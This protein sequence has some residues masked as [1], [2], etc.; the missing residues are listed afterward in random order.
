[1]LGGGVCVTHSLRFTSGVTGNLL[2]A[3]MAVEPSLPHSCEALVGL[4]TWEPH[5]AGHS[6]RSGR[7]EALPTELS[8]L[9]LNE[10]L[11]VDL[12]SRFLSNKKIFLKSENPVICSEESETLVISS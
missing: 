12:E 3:S 4:E 1:M 9:G 6:V 8:R 10:R 11:L 5:S 7:P 2:M